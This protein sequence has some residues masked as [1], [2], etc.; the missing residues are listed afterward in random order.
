MGSS[1]AIFNPA[2]LFGYAI[3]GRV[4]WA[5]WITLSLAQFGG[6]LAGVICAYSQFAMFLNRVPVPR[7]DK[8]GNWLYMQVRTMHGVCVSVGGGGWKGGGRRKAR[9]VTSQAQDMTAPPPPAHTPTPPQQ[10]RSCATASPFA[11]PSASPCGAHRT[12]PTSRRKPCPPG[13]AARCGGG[14]STTRTTWGPSPR[15][16]MNL[17]AAAP[18]LTRRAVGGWCVG[19]GEGTWAR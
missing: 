17:Q 1:S 12:S 14:P 4:T 3:L 13:R 11:S 18:P 16:S 6:G 15:W 5:H 19:G 8:D 7:K 2:V 10:T 9:F